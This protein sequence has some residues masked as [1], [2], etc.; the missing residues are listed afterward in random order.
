MELLRTKYLHSIISYQGL[1]R[2]ETLEY[3]EAALREAILNSIVHCDYSIPAHITLS[4][5]ND[6]ISLWNAGTLLEPLKIEM[7]KTNHPSLRR[8]PLIANVFFRAAYIEAWGRGTLAMIDETNKAGFP[9]PKFMEYA[10]GFELTFYRK[11]NRKKI[12]L[13]ASDFHPRDK[14]IHALEYLT[15]N[16]W[17]TNEIYQQLNQCSRNIATK[18]LQELLAQKLILREGKGRYSK[19]KLK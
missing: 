5:F 14:Q 12:E 3:P 2:V 15:D 16:I 7:L 9:V 17:I 8:N 4:I 6:R 11:E 10:G 1:V 18:D 19:Y 13:L